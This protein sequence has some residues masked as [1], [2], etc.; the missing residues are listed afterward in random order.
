MT[1]IQNRLA[2][3]SP[4]KRR[5]LELRMQMQR[6]QTAGPALVPRPRGGRLPLSFAQQ[7]LWVLDQLDPGSAAYNMP[8]PLLLRGPLDV[9][10]LER[11]LDA[12][13]ERHESLRTTFAVA[14]GED[15]PVQVIHPFVPVPLPVEDLSALTEDERYAETDRQVHADANTGFD[16]AQGPLF[17]A[18][19][20]RLQ[21]EEHVLLLCLH[22][23]ISDGWSLGILARELGAL[24]AAFNEGQPNPL[25][26]LPVQYPDFAIWQREHMAGE[27]LARH[28]E[29][30][31]TA[32][33]GAP[34]ALELPTDHPR[35]AQES[36]RGVLFRGRVSPELTGRLRAL[37][38]AEGATLFSVL[39]AGL[40]V[41]LARWSG[42]D[43][44]VIGTP[45][46]GRTRTEVEGLIG[47]FINTLPLRGQVDAAEPFR[48]MV[49]REKTA[50]LAAF[51][52]QDLPFE[53]IVEELRIA[54]DLSRNP[55]FQ[56][57]LM[58]QNAAVDSMA[59]S[60]IQLSP[61]AV[62]FDT[63]RFDLAFDVFED[64]DGGL[65]MDTEYA[66]DLFER[67]TVDRM[68]AHLLRLLEHAADAPDTP[69]GQLRMIG[70][71]ERAIVVGAAD[72]AARDWPFAPVHA[73]VA[74]QAARTP[75]AVAVEGA[76][77]ALT[78]AQ[79]DALAA[80]VAAALRARG[81]GRS[82]LVAVW[83]DR[84][85]RMV[86][87]LL[88]V[89]RAGAAYL[90]LDPE[91]PADRIQYM[92]DDSGARIVLTERALDSVLPA[93]VI[94]RIL[95]DDVAPAAASA[96]SASTDTADAADGIDPADTDP[97]ELAYV[98][99]T[100]GSTGKPKG[101]MVP[102][103]GVSGFLR[104][105]AQ[106]PG[107]R[108]DDTLLAVTTIAFDISV[109]E[110]FLP[111]TQGARV[112]VASREQAADPALLAERI[113]R[114]D[115]TVVQATP[116]TWAMLLTAGWTPR[117]GMRLLTGGEALTRPLADRL[118]AAGAEV[119]NMYGPTE[120]TIWSS[121]GRVGAETIGLGGPI[122]NT[123]LYVLDPALQ[124]A[125]LGVYG[126]LFIGGAGVA[127]GYLARPGLTAERFVPDAFGAPGSRL[128]RTGD[129]V[130]RMADGT[131]EFGGRVDFQVK[132]RGF[133]IE[134]GE[135]ES[136]LRE[137]P[138]VGAA[139][140]LVRE[141]V[142]G[143]ARLVAYVTAKD[144]GAAPVAAELR[145]HLRG[146]LPEYMV[147]PAFVV[148]DALPLTPNGKVDRK[149]LP[150][151][152]G[153]TDERAYTAP[154][155]PEEEAL[156]EI[157]REVLRL[158]R[159]GLDD[160]FFELGGHS[161]LATQ[162]LSRVRRELGVEL[163]L[164][165]FFEA[166]TVRALGERLHGAVA[167]DG[168]ALAPVERAG[169]APLSFAQERMWF[170]DRMS[171]ASGMYNMPDVLALDGPLN[172]DALRA[173]LEAV[174]A[175]HE[176][177]R[178]RYVEVDGVPMQDVLPPPRFL[179]PVDD[180]AEAA[181][182]G[183]MRAE[184]RA[185]FDL[186]TQIPIR[187]RLLRT[188]PE[189][190]VLLLTVHHIAGDAWSWGVLL[191]E[192]TQAY[193]A[194]LQGEEAAFAPLPVQYADYAVW[195]RAWL[196]GAVMEGQLAFWRG[197]LAGA[198][199]LLELPY[200]RPRP[201]EQDE[202]GGVVLAALPPETLR[203]ARQLARGDG[204]T[205]YMV[206][207]A[208]WKATLHRWS[209]E[210][211][212]V[213]G[214]P[215]A[216]RA[217]PETEGLVGLFVNT[218]ALRTDLS[219]NPSFRT[220]LGRVRDT[221]LE[222]YAHQDVPFEQMVQETGVPRS[223]A[224]TP[225]FQ[226][227]FGLQNVP[228]GGLEMEG[229]RARGM[230][231]TLETSRFDLTVL[232]DEAGDDLRAYVEYAAALFDAGTI[233]RMMGQYA[234][235][236]SAA[237]AAPD[238]PFGDLPMLAEGERDRVTREF[239]VGAPVAPPDRSIHAVFAARAA[240]APDD[241]A[242][243]WDGGRMS[244]A[245]LDAASSRLAHHLVAR[246]ARPGDG[247]GVLV[248]RGPRLIVSMLA[249]LKAGG[250]YVPLDPAY[251]V[252][253]LA[254]M[255]EEADAHLV[256]TEEGSRE[257]AEAVAGDSSSP[258]SRSL[259]FVDLDA[260][261][262]AIDAAPATS[263]GIDP[264]PGA[265]AHVIYTSGSTGKPKGVAIPHGAVVGLVR[266][267]AFA[268]LGPGS[269]WLHLAPATFDAT[270]LEVWP[271]LL[272]GGRV[273][274]YPNLPP[275][276]A[277]LAASIR[278]HGVTHLWL[279]SGLFNLVVD[280]DIGAL[281]GVRHVM[282]GGDVVSM[283]HARRV[284]QAHPDLRLT[285]GYGPT[286]NTVF[287]TG[288]DL[289]AA[290]WE[291]ASLPVGGPLPGTQAYV[292]DAALNPSPVGVPGELYAGGEG[293]AWG[294]LRRPA[295]TA[296]KFIPDPFG[297]PGS[298][299][300]RTGDLARWLPDG[301]LEFHGRADQQVKVRGF[302]IETGEIEQALRADPR[303]G[304]AAVIARADG[305]GDKRLVAYV[306]PRDGAAPTATEL[307]EGLAARLP[308]Y[309]VPGAF[310]VLD[311]IPLTPNGKVDRRALPEPTDEGAA[312]A[313][314]GPR[315]PVEQ[316][317]A[318]LWTELLGA[319]RVRRRDSFFEL[320]GH[321][322][323][324][325]R[326]LSRIR[327][328]LGVELPL[329]ALFAAPTLAA[330]A[331]Q[332][333]AARAAADGT[334][335][336]PPIR[337]QPRDGEPPLSFAQERMWFL[338]RLSG[339]RGT[340]NVPVVLELRGALDADALG[341][342]LA[343]LVARHEA[344][345]TRIASRDGTPVQHI[346][347]HPSFAL[348]VED[349]AEAELDARLDA[350]AG[351]PF[352]LAAELPIRAV[353]YRTAPDAHVL[354]MTLHHVAT[355]GWSNGILLRELAAFYAA[356]TR[357]TEAELPPLPLQYAD[358]AAWQRRWL[359]GDTLA[360]QMDFWRRQL[361][362]APPV[363]ELP[364][365]RPRPARQSF[366]GATHGFRVPDAVAQ[367]IAAFAAAEQVTTFMAGLAVFQ[368]LL[369]RY[370]QQDDVV[371]G[372]PLAGRHRAESEPIVGFFVN[373]LALRTDVSGD[374]SL[375]ELV[376]R[377]RETILDA[378]AHQ[379]LPFERLVDE[380]GLERSLDRTPVFQVVFTLNEA[381]ES[382]HGL[383]LPGIEVR[384][385][386][387]ARDTAKFDLLLNLEDTGSGL[388][389][390]FEYA[391]DL[392]D[393]ATIE[394]MGGQFVRLLEGALA[395]PDRPLRAVSAVPDAEL[396][397]LE[398]WNAAVEFPEHR[399]GPFLHV[400]SAA[401]AARTPDRVA[402]SWDGGSL[403]FAE[404]DAR[405]N[406][407][408]NYLIGL[409]VRPHARIGICMERSPEMVIGL[410]AAAK[411][412][413]AYVPVDPEYPAERKAWL[414]EDSAA[415]VVLTLGRMADELPQT[416][417]RILAVD[418]EWERIAAAP[419]T[420]PGLDI[421]PQSIAYVIYTSG[422][423]G[424]PK[425]VEVPHATIA[426]HM[427]WMRRV[428]P[429]G[430]DGVVMQKTPFGFDASVW[431]FWA[432]LMEG[433]RVHLAAPGGQRDPAYIL[434]TIRR[435]GIT[436][437]QFVPSMLALIA[438]EPGLEDCTSLRRIGSAG[439]ALA[440]EV[441]RRVAARNPAP[442][443]NLYGPT[444]ATIHAATHTCE[445][446]YD[447][448]G[449]S[450]GLPVDNARCYLLDGALR[451][452]P[453]GAVGELC[454]GG[455][456]VARGY[457]N[458]P[459]LTAE[460]FIPDPY[461]HEPGARMYRTGDRVRM[462]ADSTLQYLGRADFQVKLR[463]QRIEL[464]EIE[465]ALLRQPG[466]REAAVVVR[467]ETLA[468]YVVAGEDAP[469]DTEALRDALRAVLPESMV[470]AVIARLPALPVTPNGKVDRKALPDPVQAAAGAGDAVTPPATDTER[471]L[472]A[473]FGE[474]LPGVEAGRE[475]G[476]FDLGGHSLLA[477]QLLARVRSGFGVDLPIR[478]IFEAARLRELAARIDAA[479]RER[480]GADAGLD[481]VP[482]DRNQPL[483]LSF[484]Q[485]RMWFLDR[486]LPGSAVYA[487]PFRIHLEGMLR[488][489]ALRQA[490]EDLVHRH[491]ALRTV[492]AAQG[493]RPV[494]V[495]TPPAPFA[496]SLTD[497]SELPAELAERE[498]ARIADEEARRPFDLA[499]GP[500]LRARLL[501]TAP[502]AWRLLLTIHHV[503][504]DGWSV[505]ILFREL[506]QAYA[507]RAEGGAPALPTL[508][509]QYPD[510]AAWQR[511]W[512]SGARLEQQI[513]WWRGRLAGAPVLELPADRPRPATPTFRGEW[514]E[515]AVGAGVAQA[516]DAL[517]RAEGATLFQVLLGAFSVLLSRWSGQ[518]DV[519]VGSPVAGRGR[520]ETEA[521]VGLFVN[522]LALRTDLSGN[523]DFREVVRRV[524]TGTVDAFAHQEVPFERLVDELRI[525]R[526]LSRHPLFQVSFSV[527]PQSGA[528]LE[529]AG[530]QTSVEQTGTGTAKFDLTV[531]MTPWEGGLAG[532]L[533]YA[534]DLFDRA[535]AQRLADGFALLLTA[536]AAEPDRPLSRL[537][538][539]L[540]EAERARVL[541]E[542]SGTD[543]PVAER[544]IPALV[545]EQAARTPDAPAL[546]LGG[547]TVSYGE[548]EARANRLARHLAARGVG[549]ETVVGLVAERTPETVIHTLAIL[550]AGAAYLPLDSAYPAERLRYML[551]DARA[552]F[553]LTASG[554]PAG[555]SAT[556]GLAVVDTRAEADR[557][558]TLSASALTAPSG[559]TNLAYV[560]Y[561]SG[562]TGRPK[563]VAVTHRGL[564]NLAAWQQ[565][566]MGLRA[567]DRLLQFASY[568]FDAAVADVVPALASGA[569]LVFATRE[570]MLPGG[571]LLDTL[572][573]ERITF[574]TLPPAALAVMEPAALPDLRVVLSAGE[575]LPPAV[576]AR[577]AGA[578][579][580]HNAYGPTETTVSA[581]SARVAADD[582]SPVIGRPIDNARAYVLDAHGEPV[583][584]G[585][586]GELHVGGVGVARGYLHRPG[587][588]AERFVPDPFGAPGSRLYRTGD[589]VR[590]TAEGVLAFL[591]RIDQQL[592]VRGYRIEPGEIA[593]RLA[594]ME[595][596]RDALV[597]VRPDARG[598][599]RLVAYVAAPERVLSTAE[600][601]DGLRR[602]L[603]DY[604]VPQSY[605][606]MDRFPQ[607]PNGKTDRA[608]LPAPADPSAGP[609]AAPQGELEVAIAA[610]WATVLNVPSVG[611]N[612][613]FFEIGG[614]S[615][616]VAQLQEALRT[617]I[618]REVSMVDLFQYPTVAA[619]AAHLDAAARAEA[620]GADD[621]EKQAGR[622]R[623]ASRR[624]M[625]KRGGRR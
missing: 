322:L 371:V 449:A 553:I 394:R 6:A 4:E 613:S 26:P 27:N 233:E 443:V 598:E 264:G 144:G 238:V 63:A 498:A 605:V 614:H 348:R 246:G 239:A 75:H 114:A 618:G 416:A 364:T 331:E 587:L 525:E 372:T 300:Y 580:L 454:V 479:R 213:V 110:L 355:D 12:L 169:L 170:L 122:A 333:E 401:Q 513:R 474:L 92:L 344:L 346:D 20:L 471:A 197:R 594:E 356:R 341:G 521:M 576:A 258:V 158:D 177:L 447:L 64:A 321:S 306:V 593:A 116:A 597:L 254:Q 236:L 450:I 244:F 592:K 463:G 425:G 224:H 441:V 89:M 307:R 428:Y 579:E 539:L 518:D 619:L 423:T 369:S 550:K 571:A 275:D 604:M 488:P 329:K 281:E 231:A 5:L 260:E 436:A 301:L 325:T 201:A 392:F 131:L 600:L 117:A 195:Q 142:A 285:N 542:W 577:W 568:S 265:L 68:T 157:W 388:L 54:R 292:L 283:P 370:A 585:V 354:A 108:A 497:L 263:P 125:P 109:L 83:V 610:V 135:I 234:A 209:G 274:L 408:A 295:L 237:L 115:A 71:D 290:D 516:V 74:E 205:L 502:D 549:P 303:V 67:A 214:S 496:L 178:T 96:T 165:A 298:R 509:V 478:A 361:A 503:V 616:L 251:P 223:M 466:V 118:L 2:G 527:M 248:E 366:R 452:V 106:A 484:A 453:R 284:L 590:W 327:R 51:D 86:A 90:P 511:Q 534:T 546:A 225:V 566:R 46:A 378:Y 41:V 16:L 139:V 612:D 519:V 601:R 79:L 218:L 465:A 7:R 206:L 73:L 148:L 143:D 182:E 415:P 561:T 36:H 517:A 557:I 210:T 526:S 384:E 437:L 345:R 33:A 506:S 315:G 620:G 167:A 78:Y 359:R 459:A 249:A 473:V 30:W 380:L 226:V 141:D 491:E 113:R 185:P 621:P 520:P 55:V 49:R 305:A 358:Y 538:A 533:E 485:E 569:T 257:A 280:E 374:P 323:V 589:R 310:V 10:A 159:V 296:E 1:D 270:T 230:G 187:A 120:T 105:M 103:G 351:A 174:V 256:I 99:Y 138:A 272:S 53:R 603:P 365:D 317:L 535:T 23:S 545:A 50:S 149:T 253:R 469:L 222:A 544:T 536:L 338:D 414:L 435:E 540:S 324:A 413:C 490:L 464:G 48:Q 261:Q 438:G 591:G 367:G 77:G 111:L 268:D 475:S 191:R 431:E 558:E 162:V 180:V 212:I 434:E 14:E 229:V 567:G 420:D 62:T 98:I 339:D 70:E 102:H 543:A 288:H 397:A 379:D 483:P 399:D 586:P 207:L 243:S 133:R 156:A 128:Y 154:R 461:A 396:A 278:A 360:R 259:Q 467:G 462:A 596:V 578:V 8:S 221:A 37:A 163:P 406:Q 172:V 293:L 164:R 11:A 468:G 481:I 625:L 155:T 487:M 602:V 446:D 211:D 362:G 575:A 308:S 385:R 377:V 302:R 136:A 320:G 570:A 69:V 66:T 168:P 440:T 368:A 387:V 565:G 489:E 29:F 269:A 421:H 312:D 132:L 34:P 389:G 530:L 161:L 119:W 123:A 455:A 373:T 390:G 326:L 559:V 196:H 611:V 276:P 554:L 186:D 442:V 130:R 181:V 563:G 556:G 615:L 101:V 32:L 192:M 508:D 204:A 623:G 430:P 176:V 228:E 555:L 336:I 13:R 60:G 35:P 44:V 376:R 58:L 91:Y 95:L 319:R 515:L 433:G 88:G 202:Q 287:T 145:T 184:A 166:S 407:L 160:D 289:S 335:R 552:A 411:A 541:E 72:D 291:R 3:L 573:R 382:G 194:A 61:L 470:P 227:M 42:Q 418:T 59:L 232:L 179:L 9:G 56:V 216:G 529:L 504:A 492:F 347:A 240:A 429:T 104:S 572:R 402:V 398:A 82:S 31:R 47:F 313:G 266:E 146:R 391:T 343:D 124:P 81:A 94:D 175:R 28:L 173:A 451:H 57:Q 151:P 412:G 501:R 332:V 250:A 383:A 245:E 353:L 24:F 153:R 121:T 150:A 271:A 273:A 476:F 584:A 171:P 39:L 537:P 247:I 203:A 507:A 267:G 87:A 599:D 460:K 350:E 583:P 477:M 134:L 432:P 547:R 76:D 22:H 262:S 220:L 606:V 363:L 528:P 15:E 499:T 472:A 393:A 448:P 309:L 523:P 357:G 199:A 493:G 405:A 410:V 126:E 532:G 551:E 38:Q 400:G 482:A 417:A 381:S 564:A 316:V 282:T 617:G 279:T 624:E 522:T 318:G 200:D 403:T 328:A 439:E 17:R 152:E 252:E 147:P 444:E 215:I 422:S 514:V 581:A 562:S 588:T 609:A 524:R 183:R 622:G 457:L 277:G 342:A 241:A 426:N 112:V 43:D 100:S 107:L 314:E 352:D 458:R 93:T 505:D 607:T 129:R 299:L 255:L 337:P 25:P 560:I 330:L 219:G 21:A 208:A 375:R 340:Y 190:H 19:L 127:R 18:R 334:E 456:G 495:V 608:A 311:S 349:A 427:E 188:T 198:P 193:G 40:R 52:R 424:R 189:R 80:G 242:L 395:D 409:G 494:Q 486:L 65:R 531:Q 304:D 140:A 500:L 419:A 294:Y 404:V 97:A 582:P 137:H 510:Y 512:L 45:L 286:E 297:A 445:P 574:A 548:M 217:R 386:W 84:S 85:A 480:D 235:L 595:G